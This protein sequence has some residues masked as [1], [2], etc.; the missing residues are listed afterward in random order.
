MSGKFMG[1]IS[2]IVEDLD[3]W[4]TL[5]L[6]E[7][8]EIFPPM[9]EEDYNSLVESMNSQGFLSNDPIILID[10]APE[11]PNHSWAI[12]DGRNRHLAA[13]DAGVRPEFHQYSGDGAI[14]FVTS[15]NLDRRHLTTGQKAAVA[16]ELATLLSGQNI[17][18]GSTTQEQAAKKVGVGEATLRRY[19]Y[20]E[21]NDPELAKKVKS[22]EVPLEK[23][24][25]KIKE[26]KPNEPPKALGAKRAERKAKEAAKLEAKI[27]DIVK[28]F[29][30]TA[31]EKYEEWDKILTE[32]VMA[33]YQL[34]KGE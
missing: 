31:P 33:G 18:A 11:A 9:Q 30:E 13:M 32:A 20:V 26:Q 5:P 25:A 19:K 3:N 23:A 4:R 8:C 24:R 29:T 22:G 17:E 15:R 34:A 1:Y 21:K 27:K 28:G 6:H 2:P 10:I 14:T 12:L 16:A 7:L